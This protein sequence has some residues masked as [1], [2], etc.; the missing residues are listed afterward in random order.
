MEHQIS[1]AIAKGWFDKLE[2]HL[3]CDVVIVGAGP[4]GLVCASELA[5]SGINTTV[6]ERKLAP[7][8]GMWGGAMFFNQI[9]IPSKALPILDR[10]GIRHHEAENGLH[11]ADAVEATSALIYR[12]ASAGAAIFTGI[13][14]EDIIVEQN[15]I[16]GVVINWTAVA[17]NKMHVDPLTISAQVVLD[18]TGHSCEV[19]SILTQK[20]HVELEYP[21][22]SVVYERSL[23][24][25]AGER[26]CVEFTGQV[27]PGL[28]VCGM[29]ACGVSGSNRM[30]PIFGGMLLSGIKAAELIRGKLPEGESHA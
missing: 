24:A 13:T 21:S 12:A 11:L 23:N 3:A 27:Y 2:R 8:G 16:T 26:A 17:K 9:V 1:S 7:G 4:S 10:Y 28:F 30:G 5:S 6:I 20:N 15:R 18:A 25:S 22:R 29:A 19:V 14:A